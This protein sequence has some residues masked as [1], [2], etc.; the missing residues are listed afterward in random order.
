MKKYGFMDP[1]NC[2]AFNV[3]QLGPR[4]KISDINQLM[5]AYNH[6]YLVL[7]IVT[8]LHKTIM[9]SHC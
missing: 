9:L 4:N 7:K 6:E 5:C 8:I 3:F 2:V 1:K